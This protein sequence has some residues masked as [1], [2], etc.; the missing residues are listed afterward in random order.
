[1]VRDKGANIFCLCWEFIFW[2][3][4]IEQKAMFFPFG[5]LIYMPQHFVL[6]FKP[7]NCSIQ[8][9]Q[10]HSMMKDGVLRLS[11][12]ELVV[13]YVAAKLVV[14]GCQ[15]IPLTDCFRQLFCSQLTSWLQWCRRPG[16][17]RMP[18]LFLD[19]RDHLL[20]QFRTQMP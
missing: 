18:L 4:S 12:M 11:N 5:T 19:L 2:S 8:R 13:A 17:S 15:S 10:I 3:P 20:Y 9:F 16:V 6:H 1:M 14:L 7:D